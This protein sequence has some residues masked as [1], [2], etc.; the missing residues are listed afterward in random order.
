[1]RG[2]IVKRCRKDACRALVRE[3]RC[4]KCAGRA[5]RYYYILDERTAGARRREWSAGFDSR[6]DAERALREKLGLIDQGRSVSRDHDTL[7][8]W[9]EVWLPI[10]TT[11]G[12]RP[13]RASTADAYKRIWTRYVRD[14]IGAT[15]V[16]A[17]TARQVQ[18]LYTNLLATGG[19]GGTSL[20]PNTV[21][22]V[23]I[24]L[25]RMLDYAVKMDKVV[26]NV[27]RLAEPPAQTRPADGDFSVWSLD[28]LAAFERA[29]RSERLHALWLFLITTACR[30]GEALGA[31]WTDLDL[32]AGTWEV[33][34]SLGVVNGSPAWMEPKTQRGRRRLSLDRGTVE[35]LQAHRARQA[36]EKLALGADYADPGLVFA[37]ADGTALHPNVVTRWFYV[38][39]ERAGLPRIR[40]HDVRH[41]AITAMIRRGVPI[42]VVSERAGHASTAFTM[43]VYASVLPDMQREA[44]EGFAA[45]LF[46]SP[47]PS[48]VTRIG[49]DG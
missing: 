34:R 28:Q 24:V 47:E 32:E 35:V 9:F 7:N 33:R 44:A 26:R 39:S 10:A 17:L 5:F 23:H 21:R 49:T 41:S 18:T 12:K 19:A 20:S 31:R 38:L 36:A 43:D 4:H 11:G 13:L 29:A 2:S 40:L 48:R 8:D 15:K 45:G 14:R 42:K 22:H 1:M 25:S 37:H 16:Q 3:R 30:R 46:G 6:D 27:A